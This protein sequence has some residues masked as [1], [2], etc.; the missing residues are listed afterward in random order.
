MKSFTHKICASSWELATCSGQVHNEESILGGVIFWDFLITPE[1]KTAPWGPK[2]WRREASKHLTGLQLI[3]R[4][5]SN[6]VFIA[7]MKVSPQLCTANWTMWWRWVFIDLSIFLVGL[8]SLPHS[9]VYDK[10][11]EKGCRQR[12]CSASTLTVF[13]TLTSALMDPYPNFYSKP[14]P[15]PNPSQMKFPGSYHLMDIITT[16]PVTILSLHNK[17]I[18]NRRHL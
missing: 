14:K 6:L 7:S 4:A 15:K 9:S 12:Y 10:E 3:L 16:P 11:N 13:L 18:H 5:C 8:S 1:H 17:L 2:C